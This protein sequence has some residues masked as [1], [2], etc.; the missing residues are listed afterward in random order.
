MNH[1]MHVDD[2][3]MI[4]PSSVGLQRSLDVCGRFGLS[5]DV[6][7]NASKSYVMC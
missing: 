6:K 1:L 5:H 2:L 4:A 3:V 7:Y